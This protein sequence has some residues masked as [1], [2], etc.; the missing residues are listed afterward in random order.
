MAD[1]LVLRFDAPLQ[2]FGGPAIDAYS[3]TD[4]FPGASLLTGLIANA[5]GWEHRDAEKLTRLQGRLRFATRS[6]RDGDRLRDYQ[7]VDLGDEDRPNH[8][9]GPGWTTWGAAEEREGSAKHGTHQ[10]YRDYIADGVLTV[11]VTLAPADESPTIDEVATALRQPERPLFLGRKCCLPSGP[12]LAGR[13]AAN[14][15]L[16]ALRAAPWIRP[17]RLRGGEG[18]L[19]SAVW[20]NEPGGESDS[21]PARVAD[22]RD[23][24]NQVHTGRRFVRRGAIRR[25]GA[26]G[27]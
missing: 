11:V 27:V 1:F 14:S 10:R 17:D 7:T 22:L 6:D 26:D 13:L 5:L 2:S 12:V 4:D 18:G 15:C 19:H 24:K 9:T 20:P 25:K 23:W 16:E 8:L 21:M 3:V